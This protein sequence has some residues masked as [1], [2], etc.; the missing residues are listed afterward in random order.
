MYFTIL[1][2]PLLGSFVSGFLGQKIGITGSHII[3]CTCL[4]L[5]SILATI[6]LYEVGLCSSP[7][8]IS[9]FN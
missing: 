1:I 2:L 8:Q 3:T 4:I 9:L 5:S 7:V 6:A